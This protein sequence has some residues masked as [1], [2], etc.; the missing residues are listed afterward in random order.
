LLEGYTT[1]EQIFRL[2]GKTAFVT[3]AGSGL[4]RHFALVLAAAG[5]RVVIGGR[6]EDKL[7][8]TAQLLEQAGGTAIYGPLDVRSSASIVAAFDAAED[9][10]GAVDILVNN[11]GVSGYAALA[12]CDEDNWESIFDTNLK[13][14]WLVSREATRR[15]A[16]HPQGKLSI[17]NIASILSRAPKVGL[18]PYMA[19]KAGVEQLTKAMV[20]EWAADGVR[21]NAIA[22]GYFPSEMTE[23]LFET[24]EGREMKQ[25]IPL[26]RTGQLHEISG[27][28]LLLASDASSYMN[29]SVIA[30]DGGHLCRT[31]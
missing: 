31:L 26:R 3:G 21:I 27:P 16:L 8:E 24:R 22:P 28:L 10:F 14:V 13:G 12:D 19:S 9:N 29:G 6:R 23:G 30:V 17:I 5:A 11:A 20:L 18:G 25:R 2:D 7:K 1:M 4:G 15:K